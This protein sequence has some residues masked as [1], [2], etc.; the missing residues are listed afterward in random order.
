MGIYNNE[1][2]NNTD[3]SM[4]QNS[5]S[6][7]C[8]EIERLN[9]TAILVGNNFSNVTFTAASVDT[10]GEF[11]TPVGTVLATGTKIQELTTDGAL[12]TGLSVSTVYYSIDNGDG[13][14]SFATTQA[15]ASAGTAVNL[16][17]AGSGTNTVVVETDLTGTVKLQKNLEPTTESWIDVDNNEVLN[18]DNSQS[19]NSATTF[20]WVLRQ[21]CFASLRAVV[22]VTSGTLATDI[23]IYGRES[24]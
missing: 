6:F 7:D 20:Q 14:M 23:R 9:I 1:I 3:V 5:S 18:N 2:L 19:F 22:T 24:K 12:P 11:V 21:V 4:S 17:A 15:L 10:D 16:T 13:T 8:E